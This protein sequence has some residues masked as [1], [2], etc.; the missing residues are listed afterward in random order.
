MRVPLTGRHRKFVGGT[1]CRPEVRHGPFVSS[2][3]SRGPPAR[4]A[5]AGR[6]RGPAAIVVRSVHG[7][8]AC[9]GHQPHHD[10]H[11]VAKDA[12]AGGA[13]T[14]PR[15]PSTGGSPPPTSTTSLA[16]VDGDDKRRSRRPPDPHELPAP[17]TKPCMSISNRLAVCSG[18][19][20]HWLRGS[21]RVSRLSAGR[22]SRCGRAV[23]RWAEGLRWSARTS[24]N[25]RRRRDAPGRAAESAEG[26]GPSVTAAGSCAIRPANTPTMSATEV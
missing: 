21:A 4:A 20:G 23:S 19:G 13:T 22:G 6:R 1:G 12:P 15:P 10:P 3:L 11:A 8:T 24:D 17:T 9:R 2:P 25:G 26:Q 16:R 7:R 5:G 18:P 14:P